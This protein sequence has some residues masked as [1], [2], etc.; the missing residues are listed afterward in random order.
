MC[1]STVPS[2]DRNFSNA[3]TGFHTS[4]LPSGACART[5][6]TLVENFSLFASLTPL[7]RELSSRFPCEKEPGKF[8]DYIIMPLIEVVLTART[9]TKCFDSVVSS[10]S[11][12][13][14]HNIFLLCLTSPVSHESWT[15]V[16]SFSPI[17][18]LSRSCYKSP[19]SFSFAAHS[20]LF[21]LPWVVI[22]NQTVQTVMIT[23]WSLPTGRPDCWMC[24]KCIY[25]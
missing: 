18:S 11:F 4:K 2:R 3:S 17:L 24:T 8:I 10:F 19:L 5:S 7:W 12:I 9:H 14:I 25:Q 20:T 16:E 13:Y 21:C 23:V 6:I 15:R 22:N 1:V